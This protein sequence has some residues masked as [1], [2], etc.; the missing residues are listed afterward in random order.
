MGE[1]PKGDLGTSAQEG[2]LDS[3]KRAQ[4]H[5]KVPKGS[6]NGAS[7]L[8][9][10]T[11]DSKRVPRAVWGKEFPWCHSGNEFR[12]RKTISLSKLS[13]EKPNLKNGRR[14]P[15]RWFLGVLW[16]SHRRVTLG[17][18]GPRRPQESSKRT[19]TRAQRH[20]QENQECRK[21]SMTTLCTPKPRKYF[22]S[23]PVS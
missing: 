2:P 15:Y 8:S 12:R 3:S 4:N 9:D 22:A 10:D 23:C 16:G 5:E 14:S 18:C 13:T 21:S 17:N 7:S 11:R 1:S 20:Q 19:K 6:S